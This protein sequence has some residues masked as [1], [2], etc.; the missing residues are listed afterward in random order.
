M[1]NGLWHISVFLDVLYSFAFG[2]ACFSQHKKTPHKKANK[3]DWGRMTASNTETIL[4][5]AITSRPAFRIRNPHHAIASNASAQPWSLSRPFAER[6][7]AESAA[8]A[9]VLAIGPFAPPLLR[10]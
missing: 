10:R 3:A 4:C 1:D 7:A 2:S 6:A 9:I 5:H 8:D